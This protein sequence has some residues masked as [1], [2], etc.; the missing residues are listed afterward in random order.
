MMLKITERCTMG[1]VHC[2]NDAKAD[3]K[4]MSHTIL[5]DSLDFLR[6]NRIGRKGL[7]ITGGEPTEHRDFDG[8]I[9]EII[10]Y[11]KEHRCFSMLAIT[12]NG[13][14]IGKNHE[15]FLGYIQNASA[16]GICLI[17][18][19]SADTRYYPR[20]IQTHK[21]IFRQPGFVLCDPCITNIYPQG[22]ALDNGLPWSS[23]ASKCF[24]VRAISH[25]ISPKS[26]LEDIE[27]VLQ[28]SQKFC[29]PHIGVDGSIKLGE[30]DLCPVCASI[31]DDMPTI[32]KKIRRFECHRCDQINERLPNPLKKLIQ[33][34][35]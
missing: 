6:K 4:D 10:R 29:T 25:Q 22:R 13:E 34:T 9:N 11:A 3:G 5:I 24:N 21:R 27:L 7:V 26:T 16:A 2:M 23:K 30:S 15:R 19:V 12:T 20:R 1:C 32:M 35:P 31:Y 28:G 14:A 18:Q 17:F 33:P 8:V